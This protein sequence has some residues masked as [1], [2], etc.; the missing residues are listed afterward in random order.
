MTFIL[1]LIVGLAIA[2]AV[3]ALLIMLSTRIV[4]GFSPKFF[5]T[6]FITAVAIT[7]AGVAAS[8]LLGMVLGSGG[9]SSLICLVVVFVLYAAIIN[10]MVKR[11]DGNQMGFG[12]SAL[13]TLVLLIIE[14]VIGVILVLTFGMGMVGMMSGA[15]H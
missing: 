9:L 2:F 10:V 5:P 4:A 3:G 1:Y 8:W 7:I 6:A 14:I 15:V 11:P 12:K 13:V